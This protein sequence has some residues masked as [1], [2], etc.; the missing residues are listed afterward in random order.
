M[1]IKLLKLILFKMTIF[2]FEAFMKKYQLKNDTMNESD[3]QRIYKHPIYP[4]DSKLH[5]DKGFVKIDN[6]SMGRTHSTCFIKKDNKSQYYDSFGFQFD[7]F[8]L[9]RLPKL[10][11]YHNYKIQ[12]INSK[13]C[14]SYCLYFFYI[15]ERM[16]DFDALLKMFFEHQFHKLKGR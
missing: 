15:I 13:F 3:L 12:D 14:G 8:P 10:M 2:N 5:S 11:V 4:R 6:G 16:K 1:E 7:K 9:K